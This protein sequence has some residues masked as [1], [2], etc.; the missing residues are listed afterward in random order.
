MQIGICS[1]VKAPKYCRKW[2]LSYV[3]YSQ[4]RPSNI[5]LSKTVK[6]P[7]KEHWLTASC[8]VSMYLVS[9]VTLCNAQI[10]L[11]KCNSYANVSCIDA[12]QTFKKHNCWKQLCLSLGR[13]KTWKNVVF[14]H[15][16][17]NGYTPLLNL[18]EQLCYEWIRVDRQSMHFWNG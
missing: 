16:L 11:N 4:N 8:T 5:C 17:R 15:V 14:L 1:L 9:F 3:R 10:W 12:T 6:S 7:L 2:L 13:I 18:L